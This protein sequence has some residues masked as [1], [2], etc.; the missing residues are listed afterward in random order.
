V[1]HLGGVLVGGHQA[2]IGQGAEYLVYHF[3]LFGAG[4][5]FVNGDPPAGVCLSVVPAQRRQAQENLA[6]NLA[7]VAV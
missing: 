6:G 5:Q 2:G 1:G 7:L 4:R 3:S